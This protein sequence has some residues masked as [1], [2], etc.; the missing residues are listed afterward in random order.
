MT[1]LYPV[2]DLTVEPDLLEARRVVDPAA[3]ANELRDI[4]DAM[5]PA[6]ADAK[7]HESGF[8]LDTVEIAL[9][10]GAEGGIGFVAKGSAEASITVRFSRAH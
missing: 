6:V 2:V 10:I 4:A 9:T 3:L 7:T 1:V 8:G 5:G